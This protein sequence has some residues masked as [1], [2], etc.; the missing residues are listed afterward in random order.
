M[1]QHL[2]VPDWAR[3]FD[4]APAPFLL[5]TPGL[6]IV[7]ANR[8]RLEAT[9]TT[10]EDQVGRHLF[11]AFPMPPDDPAADGL[12]NLRATLEEAL[13]TRRPVVMPIQ[14]YDI[15]RAGG[16]FE[17][18]YWSPVHVPVLDEEGE[19]AFLLHRSDDITDYV[20][21]RE[22]ARGEVDRGQRRVA[23]VE[24]DLYRRTRE[25]EE[26]NADLRAL[27]ERQRRTARALAGLAAT[28]SA[29]AAAETRADLV[30]RLSGHGREVL[31]ADLLVLALPEPGTGDLVLTAPGRLLGSRVAA[32][33]QHPAAVAAAG[34]AVLVPHAGA[35]P[36]PEPGLQAWAALPLRSGGRLL[37]SLTVGWRTPQSLEDDD[38]RVLDA[39]AVQ[40]AQA[41]ER[42]GRLEDERRAASV[43]RNLAESL[44]RSMLTEP[45]HRPGLDVAVRYRP[46]AREAEVGGDW[47]D[48][49]AG[50]AGTTL[51][52][53]DVTGHD[54]DAAAVMGQVRNLLRGI[55]HAVSGPPS[56]VLGTLDR[57][58]ADLG[59][60]TLVTA[61]LA[62]VGPA[63][64]G[65]GGRSLTWSTAGHPPP[66][67]VPP[68]GRPRLLDR[69]GG[70]LLGV[71]PGALRTDVEETLP[72]GSTVVLYTDGLVERRDADLDA[73]LARLLDAAA[74]L[75]GRPADDVCDAL[76]SRLAP[77]R[78]D[79]VALL[80]LRV[81]P[82]GD[83]PRG[84]PSPGPG[85]GVRVPAVPE[86]NGAVP[87][88]PSAT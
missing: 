12:V 25:L 74:D 51:V 64:E 59:V 77:D 57:A 26:L 10:L 45:P 36:P 83:R 7:H 79:D 13:E 70:L 29:L 65:G 18:R 47:Y 49:F 72:P 22:E 71:R 31:G 68:A 11:E 60:S 6:V 35:Q 17:E 84:N 23:D 34:R 55:A 67:L 78:S 43:A 16:G 82:A 86:P 61:V 24:A 81:L 75:P 80:A 37:G 9:G 38:V 53:G 28:V 69:A 46:A 8:A 52:I 87:P 5:L 1:G 76:L 85:R 56:R 88:W 21:Q 54:V 62:C 42:V 19:V 27:G 48:V 30:S 50:G 40:T 14:K 41:L 73:G 4:A 32:G 3:V 33:A 15:P 20:R 2:P 44:Q 58:L 63:A 66:L 39:V